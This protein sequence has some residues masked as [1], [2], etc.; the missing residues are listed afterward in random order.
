M[1]KREKNM[2]YFRQIHPNEAL[3]A[4]YQ[5]K[6]AKITIQKRWRIAGSH[7]KKLAILN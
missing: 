3:A 1:L 5:G 2:W 7:K 6:N 4:G